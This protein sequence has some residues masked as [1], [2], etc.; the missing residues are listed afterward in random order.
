MRAFKEQYDCQIEDFT[1]GE[2]YVEYKE[3]QTKSRQDDEES[4][5]KRARKYNT[6]IW[7]TDGG[8]RDPY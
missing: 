7:K 6:K 4:S 5:G 3:S 1:A 2:E 8:E